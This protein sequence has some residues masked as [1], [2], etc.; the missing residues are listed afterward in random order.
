MNVTTNVVSAPTN[1][2]SATPA[3]SSPATEK[4]G[5]VPAKAN[6]SVVTSTAE[7]NA[8]T[9]AANTLDAA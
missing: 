6:T 9:G 7:N 4:R 3:S 5:P 1:V 8:A 2:L